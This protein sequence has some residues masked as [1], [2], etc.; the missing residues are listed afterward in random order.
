[1]DDLKTLSLEDLA[2]MSAEKREAITALFSTENPTDEQVEQAEALAA[3][4]TSIEGEISERETAAT[5]RSEKFAALKEQFSAE[6]AEE[7]EEAEEAAETEE[8]E[9]QVEETEEAEEEE[10]VVA[11]AKPR[12]PVRKLASKT[13]R[14]SAPEATKRSGISITASADVP[15][16]AAGQSIAD[17]TEVAKA[18]TNRAKGFP[19]FNGRTAAQGGKPQLHKFGV[20]SLQLDFPEELT[21]NRGS[22]DLS[23]VDY[24]RSEAR[25]K[26]DQGEGSLVA[27]GGWCAPSETI[28]DLC[29]GETLD[30]ILSVPEINVAR[31]GI[32]FTSG[33]DFASLYTNTGFIQTEAEAMAGEEKD[34]YEITCPGFEDVRLDAIGLCITVPILTESAYPELVRRVVSGS[35]IAHQHRVNASVISRMVTA[36]G[37]ARVITGM[38][39]TVTDSLE[40]LELLAEQRRQHYRLGL[41]STLEVVVPFWVR[42]AFRSDIARRNGIAKEVVTD[43]D[44]QAHFRARNLNVQFVYDWQGLDED[45]EVYP[46]TYNALLYPAGTFVKGVNDVINLSAV[47]DA[48]SLQVNTYTGLF[49]EQGLLVAKTCYDSD[50]VTLPICNSGAQG[51]LE[52][53]CGGSI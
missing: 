29:D 13:A 48:A 9:A 39:S 47:Y 40:G 2:A 8:V 38:G 22:D 4:I 23:V 37:A 51:A 30:G 1:M 6:E 53:T 17:L 34:C 24:A 12:N 3:D 26:S 44:I 35:L 33:P 16:F 46:A 15:E 10:A 28:Y 18:V 36:S 42:S 41:N 49:M 25:L 11:A 32:N 21:V 27:A 50:L 7:V 20:A 19:K 5:A 45:A 31:G 43:A 14:P 52:I